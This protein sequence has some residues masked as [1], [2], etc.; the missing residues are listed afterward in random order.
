MQTTTDR[1]KT[2]GFKLADGIKNIFSSDKGNDKTSDQYVL[3]PIEKVETFE[4]SIDRQKI[5]IDRMH[6]TLDIEVAEIEVKKLAKIKKAK[7]KRRTFKEW[8]TVLKTIFSHKFEKFK[9]V[10]V[11]SLLLFVASSF[12]HAK[13]FQVFLA[14][15][16][17][18]ISPAFLLFLSIL[19]SLALEGL[20]TSLYEEYQ[21][22]L[23]NSIYALS[24]TVILSMGYYQYHLGSD[25]VIASWRT[26][27]GV[28][29]LAGLYVAH[30]SMR[31]KEFWEYRKTWNQ[32]PAVFRRELNGLFEKVLSE[33]KAGNTAYKLN[34]RDIC[35]TYNL[36]SSELDRILVRKG[37][38]SKKYIAQLP[39][40]R[41]EKNKIAKEKKA[42]LPTQNF[43][44]KDIN[45][46]NGN[47][48]IKSKIIVGV[49]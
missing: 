22:R 3:N 12:I 6:Q 34:H 44:E 28:I 9:A 24:F 36:K 29:T 27:L 25:L 17:P 35:R 46:F 49:N 10:F 42:N 40:R 21:D 4:D 33:H 48:E 2:N 18:D 14:I 15:F 23:A 41:S 43:Q 5:E 45:K 31:T 32:L 1:P 20:A 38:R 30:R 26:G 16:L 19:I 11:I 8:M 13:S 7:A 47:A 37:L 39:A